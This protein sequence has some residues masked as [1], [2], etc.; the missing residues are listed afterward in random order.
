MHFDTCRFTIG[1]DFMY[2]RQ[3][4]HKKSFGSLAYSCGYGDEYHVDI[5]YLPNCISKGDR[6]DDPGDDDDKCGTAIWVGTP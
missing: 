2:F 1:L 4:S 6:A 5:S 3:N